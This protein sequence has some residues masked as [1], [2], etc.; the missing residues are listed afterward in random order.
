MQEYDTHIFV[1]DPID[2]MF[3]NKGGGVAAVPFGLL[4]I[5]RVTCVYS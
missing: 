1:A 3:K 4:L 2:Q 5:P